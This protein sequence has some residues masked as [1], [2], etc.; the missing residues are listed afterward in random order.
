MKSR[1]YIFN[2]FENKIEEFFLLNPNYKDNTIEFAKK[3]CKYLW[4]L[5]TIEERNKIIEDIQQII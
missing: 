1:S 5:L 4:T 3:E 2:R